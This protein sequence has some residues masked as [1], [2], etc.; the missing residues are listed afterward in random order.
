[1]VRVERAVLEH[2]DPGGAES[3]CFGAESG[4]LG[5]LVEETDPRVQDHERGLVRRRQDG[6]RFDECLGL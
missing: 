2:R 1:L 6:R 4:R 3:E 5:D